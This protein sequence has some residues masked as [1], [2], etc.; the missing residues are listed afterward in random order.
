[1]GFFQLDDKVWAGPKFEEL[2]EQVGP[3]RAAE[4]MGVWSLAGAR[5]RHSG[6]TA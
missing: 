1:M 3:A 4:A 5:C 6:S 2:L